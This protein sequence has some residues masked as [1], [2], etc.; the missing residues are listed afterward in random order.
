LAQLG[1]RCARPEGP[2]R[3]VAPRAIT[4]RRAALN[5]LGDILRFQQGVVDAER[6]HDSTLKD[7]VIRY[8]D[9][10]QLLNS[11]RVHF[12][13]AESANVAIGCGFARVDRAK[14]AV[15]AYKKAGFVP[16]MPEVR[17]PLD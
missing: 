4:I 8:H 9:F 15:K 2:R 1:F 11:E 16:Q 14:P 17:L 5:D 6:P 7:G 13:I 12:V 10:E 3:G